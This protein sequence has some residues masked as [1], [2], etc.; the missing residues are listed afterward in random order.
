[1][2]TPL[3]VGILAHRYGAKI[4]LF[5]AIF[6]SS[7]ATLFTPVFA[8]M[9]WPYLCTMRFIIGMMQGSVCPCL[10]T[11]LSKWIHPTERSFLSSITYSGGKVG[12]I[13]TLSS[14]G[15]IAASRLGWP[16]I[17]YCGGGLSLIWTIIW[18]A[19]GCNDP[20][21]SETIS[22]EEK[23]FIQSANSHN[24]NSEQK[25]IPWKDIMTSPPF[26]CLIF[27]H[28]AASWGYFLLLTE[29]PSYLSSV[30]HFDIKQV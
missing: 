10:H 27:V 20:S 21:E 12:I 5:F 28:S 3:P 18:L 8:S 6:I 19:Y 7:I 26:V 17:F 1:M 2:I 13:L 16:G 30:L 23:E 9:G 22:K 29:M 14:S 11:L 4:P 15:F 25:P 24:T